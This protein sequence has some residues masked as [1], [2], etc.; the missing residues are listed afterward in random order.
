MKVPW[1][2]WK[3]FWHEDGVE[4]SGEISLVTEPPG[5]WAETAATRARTM[6]E[7]SIFDIDVSGRRLEFGL[8]GSIRLPLSF[9]SW[10][11]SD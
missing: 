8:D 11:L 4:E 3:V 9:R 2:P 1:P 7:K 5:P 10:L 6:L